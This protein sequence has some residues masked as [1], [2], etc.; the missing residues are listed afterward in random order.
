MG[1]ASDRLSESTNEQTWHNLRASR[2]TELF[3]AGHHPKS[4]CD[5]IGNSPDVAMRHY[6]QTI[7]DDFDAATRGAALGAALSAAAGG[8]K[9]S[10][11]N[12]RKGEIVGKCDDLPPGAIPCKGA[13][14]GD[15]GFEPVTSAV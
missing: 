15:T 14:M 1:R 2:E 4:V 8:R 11:T 9:E 13:G 10:Q 12:S 6:V 5:W 7:D 3:R